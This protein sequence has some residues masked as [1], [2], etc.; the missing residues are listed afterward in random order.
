MFAIAHH[1]DHALIFWL[2][3]SAIDVYKPQVIAAANL[4]LMH[5]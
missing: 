3:L 5:L 4:C 1:L 2:I